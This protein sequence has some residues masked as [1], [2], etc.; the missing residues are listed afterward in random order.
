MSPHRCLWLPWCFQKIVGS[1][2]L[3]FS[4]QW[5][6]VISECSCA[7]LLSHVQLFCDPM[8][9][10]LSGSSVHGFSKQEYWSELLFP[11]PGDLPDPW[12][13]PESPVSCNAGEL[14]TAWVIKESMKVM[15]EYSQEIYS[16]LSNCG[17]TF[18]SQRGTFNQ[19]VKKADHVILST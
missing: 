3:T 14:I 19:T 16:Q 17:S 8:D 13:K 10:S 11:P 1:S 6:K 7:Q 5:M 2:Q 4:R 18:E 15:S 12:I 9:C